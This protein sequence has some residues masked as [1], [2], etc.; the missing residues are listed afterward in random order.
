MAGKTFSS[1][2]HEV[3]V[4]GGSGPRWLCHHLAG[5]AGSPG[6]LC[7]SSAYED[8]VFPAHHKYAKYVPVLH[9][10]AYLCI[11]T[12]TLTR[13]RKHPQCH[14]WL[15][16][17]RNRGPSTQRTLPSSEPDRPLT[18]T[19]PHRRNQPRH[20]GRATRVHEPTGHTAGVEGC[21]CTDARPCGNPLSGSLETRVGSVLVDRADFG[22]KNLL[23][24]NDRVC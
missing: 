23:P 4:L 9:V 3:T 1:A 6:Q 11:S 18:G 22:R 12:C 14:P 5:R 8:I 21:I 19:A 17:S 10:T 15:R 7:S 16:R 13:V 20:A 2:P 24:P